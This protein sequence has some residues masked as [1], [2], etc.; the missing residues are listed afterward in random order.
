VATCADGRPA[1]CDV[2]AV[3]GADQKPVRINRNS[4]G[5]LCLG[6]RCVTVSIVL[7]GDHL[8]LD[9][10]TLKPANGAWCDGERSNRRAL[11]RDCL[12]LACLVPACEV[13]RVRRNDIA[14]DRFI[15]GGQVFVAATHHVD[16]MFCVRERDQLHQRLW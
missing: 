12:Q 14:C 2:E 10:V 16:C 6:E 7:G 11:D 15:I 9:L 1:R 13:I 4:P 8:F 5:P 3:D